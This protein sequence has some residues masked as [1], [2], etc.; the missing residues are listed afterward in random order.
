MDVS[1][2]AGTLSLLLGGKCDLCVL[3]LSWPCWLSFKSQFCTLLLMRCEWTDL[4]SWTDSLWR[5]G[6]YT[7]YKQVYRMEHQTVY[8]CCP[9]WAQ[10]NSEPGCLHSKL[11]TKLWQNNDW[12]D[13][14][15]RPFWIFF[16]ERFFLL[17]ITGNSNYKEVIYKWRRKSSW[18][19]TL[20]FS[21][22]W[23]PVPISNFQAWL[24]VFLKHGIKF[25]RLESTLST[26][27][28]TSVED[29]GLL[30][31]YFCYTFISGCVFCLRA[32]ICSYV[33]LIFV[34]TWG[35]HSQSLPLW[36]FPLYS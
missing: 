24:D 35:L 3:G 19:S 33:F 12:R 25:K 27:N 30:T 9:G 28:E 5:S 18:L 6:Y 2:P 11:M 20:M 14:I 21:I 32:S 4:F 26:V 17:C 16:L 36:F 15:L 29:N 22:W 8:K 23:E 10:Q 7:V 31:V 34:P 1:C 13:H